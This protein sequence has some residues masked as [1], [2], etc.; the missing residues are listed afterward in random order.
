MDDFSQ[1]NRRIPMRWVALASLVLHG[2]LAFL[3]PARLTPYSTLCIVLAELAALCACLQTSRRAGSPSRALWWMLALSILLAATA[4]SMDMLA[5]IMGVTEPNP[6]PGLQVLFSSLYGV[7]LLLAVSI[8]F[9][10][11]ALRPIRIVNACLSLATG[12]LFCV[13]VFSVV[14]IHGSNQP[15][16][17]LFICSMFDALDLFLAIAAT[18]RAFGS[19]QLQERRFFYIASV[20]LWVNAVLPAIHNREFP[21]SVRD[22]G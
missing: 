7:P 20:F 17:I 16:N 4:M 2:F 13:L 6:V 21:I 14:S 1:A 3:L 8:Q 12:A 11:R 22:G 15:A 9:D 5:E 18:I 19:D 10:P